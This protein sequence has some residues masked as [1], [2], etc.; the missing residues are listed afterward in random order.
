M[1]VIIVKNKIK[2]YEEAMRCAALWKLNNGRTLCR[3]CHY[4][5]DT[6]GSKVLALL[7]NYKDNYDGS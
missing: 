5:T 7:A 6:Y 4:K 3:P 2:T 1:S